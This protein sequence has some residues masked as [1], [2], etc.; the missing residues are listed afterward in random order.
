[1]PVETKSTAYITAA[2]PKE[3]L[4]RVKEAAKQDGRPVSTWIWWNIKKILDKKKGK[5]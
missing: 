3:E 1:M 5:P 2:I 4:P